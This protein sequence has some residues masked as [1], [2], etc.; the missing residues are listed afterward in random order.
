MRRAFLTLMMTATATV[1]VVGF[2]ASPASAEPVTVSDDRTVGPARAYGS[3]TAD[4]GPA[5]TP[6]GGW[7]V[8]GSGATVCAFHMSNGYLAASGVRPGVCANALHPGGPVGDKCVNA[9]GCILTGN[10]EVPSACRI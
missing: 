2:S 10:V 7:C 4:P 6:A 9:H 3:T 1:A 5:A 8:A